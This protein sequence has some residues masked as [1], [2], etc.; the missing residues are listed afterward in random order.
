[1]QIQPEPKTEIDH[2]VGSS[3]F[4]N[5]VGFTGKKIQTKIKEK[6]R[7]L[8]TLFFFVQNYNLFVLKDPEIV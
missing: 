7:Q 3:D 2:Y 6:F 8:A 5:L 1:M 4:H